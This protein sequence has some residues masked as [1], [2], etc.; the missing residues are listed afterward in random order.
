MVVVAL[1]GVALSRSDAGLAEDDPNNFYME[2]EWRVPEGLAFGMDEIARIIIP[3]EF[4]DQFQADVPEYAGQV[5]V[6][7]EV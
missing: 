7:E 4:V 1:V 2:R 3:R 6:A 5:T